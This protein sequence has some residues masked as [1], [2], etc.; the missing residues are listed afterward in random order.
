MPQNDKTCHLASRAA[1][2]VQGPDAAEFLQNIFTN[3]IRQLT[4][5]TPLQ[6]NLLLTPQGQVLHDVF[7]LRQGENDYTIDAPAARKADLLRRLMM[8]RLR[9]KVEVGEDES[10]QIYA[11]APGGL[12]DPRAPDRLP[13]RLYARD[14]IA[15]E[16]E[17]PYDDLCI[18]LGIPPSAAMRFEKDF[19]HDLGLQKLHAIAWD[20]GCFI[21]QE[22][23]AR[24]EHRGLAKKG[25]YVVTGEDLSAEAPLTDAAGHDAGEMRLVASDGRMGLAILKKLVLEAGQG[26]R[27]GETSLELAAFPSQYT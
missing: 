27:Q 15:A 4:A 13:L 14:H 23:A 8:F 16:P 7:I 20:K 25:L 22:V 21:G 18:S 10:L 3:D 5:A 12:P 11:G 6:Y 19:V 24:V 17:A 9:A 26:L 2:R 1:L